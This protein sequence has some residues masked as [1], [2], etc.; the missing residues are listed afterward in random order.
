MIL[1]L[2][3]PMINDLDTRPHG[4]MILSAHCATLCHDPRSR[5]QATGE[6]IMIMDTDPHS[7]LLH[8]CAVPIHDSSSMLHWNGS[9][10]HSRCVTL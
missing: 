7:H 10:L 2:D 1:D 8:G 4:L 5:L 6:L 3:P 9:R